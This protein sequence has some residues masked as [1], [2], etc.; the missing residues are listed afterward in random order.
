MA[1][2]AKDWELPVAFYFQVLMQGTEFSF[3]EVS[4]L[5]TE[6]ETETIT[7]GG[8][9]DYSYVVPKQVKHGNLVLKRALKP[10]NQDEVKWLSTF[11]NGS[12]T[13]PVSTVSITINLLQKDGKPLYSWNCH[14]AYPVKWETEP[15]DSEKNNILIE[16]LEFT[17]TTIERVPCQ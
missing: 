9:N 10:L 12:L 6:L 15:L 2:K 8:N 4:G 16:T 5:T 14:N 13:F 11:F 1:A 17:Y 7:E 3:K